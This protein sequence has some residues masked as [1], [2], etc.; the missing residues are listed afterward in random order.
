MKSRLAVPAL[1]LVVSVASIAAAS[2]AAAE[3]TQPDAC[4]GVFSSS[5]AQANPSSG[6]LVS[7]LAHSAP[8]ALGQV[9]SQKPTG[10]TGCP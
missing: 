8:G 10:V 4:F 2:A 3:P 1:T 7:G 9:A 5:F 6:R